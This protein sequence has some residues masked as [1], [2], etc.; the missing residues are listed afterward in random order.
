MSKKL[1]FSLIM[2]LTALCFFA[3]QSKELRTIKI[4]LGTFKNPKQNPDIPRVKQNLSKA[5]EI[6]PNNPEIYHLWGRVYARENNF[7]EMDKAFTKCDELTDQFKALNDTIRMMESDTLFIHSAVDAY[8]NQEYEKVLEKTKESII[9]WKYNFQPY[10]YGADAAFRINKNDEAYELAKA[11]YQLVPDTVAMAKLYGQ[12]CISTERYD[13]AKTVFTR[14][15]DI[16]PSNADHYFNL[17]EIYMMEGDTTKSLDY[18]K[19]GLNKD[20]DNAQGWMSYASISFMAS[21]YDETI[22]AF[23]HYRSLAENVSQDDYFLYLL[24]LYQ[25]KNYEKARTEL[26]AF[27][28]EYPEYCDAWQVLGNTYVYLKMKKEAKEANAKYDKCSGN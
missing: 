6:F 22:D 17:G 3:C 23:E 26:E 24:A 1:A 9:C 21:R 27:T 20:K 11:G 25:A 7:V 5:Q 13:D 4:E 19:D 2:V 14:L 10:L 15:V 8:N 16:D 18:Y 12:M 28:M